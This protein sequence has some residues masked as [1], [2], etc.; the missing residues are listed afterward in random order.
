MNST[1]TRIAVASSCLLLAG[2]AGASSAAGAPTLVPRHEA[3]AMVAPD[4]GPVI[5]D[6]S[7]GG[8]GAGRFAA[9]C[10]APAA[11]PVPV[12]VPAAAQHALDAEV[13][14]VVVPGSVA[15]AAAVPAQAPAAAR[16]A[17]AEDLV[18]ADSVVNSAPHAAISAM[19]ADPAL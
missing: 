9:N 19:Q 13:N 2:L 8:C 11:V 7:P 17:M 18:P 1:L 5:G 4:P 3:V 15:A 10:A 6:A 12:R 14:A 16:H